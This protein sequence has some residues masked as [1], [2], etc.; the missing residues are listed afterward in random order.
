[1]SNFPPVISIPEPLVSGS[2]PRRDPLII[3]NVLNANRRLLLLI[4]GSNL[5][6]DTSP[7][8]FK[9]L[10]LIRMI[11]LSELVSWT[12][13]QYLRLP[14]IGFHDHAVIVLGIDLNF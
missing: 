11:Q 10:L 6:L 14:N 8:I 1:M 4:I 12:E 9:L 7:Q 3:R 2:P 5:I 13:M